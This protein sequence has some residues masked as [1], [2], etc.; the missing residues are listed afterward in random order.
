MKRK[1]AHQITKEH[2]KWKR[3]DW[4]ND[5]LVCTLWRDEL[6]HLLYIYMC[7]CVC[8]GLGFSCEDGSV[9]Q[10]AHEGPIP[11]RYTQVT[12]VIWQK[13]TLCHS[14]L[15]EGKCMFNPWKWT[16]CG[17]WCIQANCNASCGLKEA[18]KK[19]TIYIK[20]FGKKKALH[21]DSCRHMLKINQDRPS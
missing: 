15:T 1:I 16:T 8:L 12:W 2:C 10:V 6:Y 20:L 18:H 9:W 3:L 11:H 5:G 7:V 19:E 4:S 13:S 21:S 14:S 17:S